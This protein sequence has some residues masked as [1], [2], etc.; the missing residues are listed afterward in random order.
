MESTK[1]IIQYTEMWKAFFFIRIFMPEVRY[2]AQ[3]VHSNSS[4]KL[5]VIQL[6]CTIASRQLKLGMM[7]VVLI[8][9]V[10]YTCILNERRETTWYQYRWSAFIVPILR[11]SAHERSSSTLGVHRCRPRRPTRHILRCIC[12]L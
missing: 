3:S 8:K 6:Y 9:L 11:A 7:R 4:I 1:S 5:Y 10:S 12:H 2:R